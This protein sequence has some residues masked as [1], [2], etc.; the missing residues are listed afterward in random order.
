MLT[1]GTVLRNRYRILQVLGSG[2][3]GDTYLAEDEDL[4][5]KPRCVVKQLHPKDNNPETFRIAKSLFEREA[6]YLYRIG[7]S[8][9]QIPDLYAH[10]TEGGNFYLVQEFIDGHNLTQ[11]LPEGKKLSESET[12]RLLLD[13]LEVLAFVHQQNVIHRDIKLQNLMRRRSDG[14]IILIDFGAVKDVSVLQTNSQ[15]LTNMTVSIGSPGYMPSEQAQGKPKLSSDVYAVGMIGIQAL[16]GISPANLPEDVNTGEILW[17]NL[18]QVNPSFAAVLDK[19]THYHFGQRYRSALEALEGL[20]AVAVQSSAEPTVVLP[21]IQ[22]AP[23]Q[24]TVPPT[25]VSSQGTPAAPQGT[26]PPTVASPQGSTSQT[27]FPVAILAGVVIAAVAGI[28]FWIISRRPATVVTTAPP[29]ET[30]TRSPEPQ[31]TPTPTPRETFTPPP[32]PAPSPTRTFQKVEIRELETYKHPSGIYSMQIPKGWKLTDSSQSGIVNHVWLDA[33]ENSLVGVQIFA[34]P[35]T[36]PQEIL[37]KFVQGVFGS[38]PDFN[39]GSTVNHPDGSISITWY[40]T[41]TSEGVTGKVRGD[42][43]ITK[44]PD[45]VVLKTVGVLADQFDRLEPT[46]KQILGSFDINTSATLP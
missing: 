15:G 13:I 4:P 17:K 21:T 30:A 23:P 20:R 44:Y 41:S 14:K 33:F 11:E 26:V 3:F 46:F 28:G 27:K 9:P 39:L 18:V 37:T 1:I 7:N 8:H 34:D 32:T 40:F 43:Y 22:S 10:F 2:G 24:G 6:E 16:T 38:F 19:M 25:V 12:I 42:T 5:G 36:P 35:G 45:R 29:P 31:P